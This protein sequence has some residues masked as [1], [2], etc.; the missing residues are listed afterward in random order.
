MLQGSFRMVQEGQG[1]GNDV[2]HPPAEEYKL[3]P[4]LL[5][6]AGEMQC[7]AGRKPSGQP[8]HESVP[9]AHCSIRPAAQD[10]GRPLRRGSPASPGG[11]GHHEWGHP[12]KKH[13]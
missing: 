6:E 7:Y 1:V 11:L 9:N 10:L 13:A 8:Y 3:I 2:V 12:A 4:G 5:D